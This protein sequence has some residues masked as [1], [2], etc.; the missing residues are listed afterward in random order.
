MDC[1]TTLVLRAQKRALLRDFSIFKAFL[2]G[3]FSLDW[4]FFSGRSCFELNSFLRDLVLFFSSSGLILHFGIN[5]L[6]SVN[7]YYL[8]KD[9]QSVLFSLHN[10]LPNSFIYFLEVYPLL[11]SVFI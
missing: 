11:S 1:R 7:T 3:R 4:F 2:P 10:S 9:F 6:G 5:L 8:I